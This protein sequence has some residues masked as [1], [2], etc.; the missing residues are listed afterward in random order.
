MSIFLN[1]IQATCLQ[2]GDCISIND[3]YNSVRLWGQ[4]SLSIYIFKVDNNFQEHFLII[5]TS[6]IFKN[7]YTI[8]LYFR[9]F[10]NVI[11][12]SVFKSGLWS[13]IIWIKSLILLASFMTLSKLFN[14]S[15]PVSSFVKLE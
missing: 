5:R 10:K 15:K 14:M 2:K 1:G 6:E 13:Q 7:S 12:I 4:F 9:H 3:Y 8:T 11:Y